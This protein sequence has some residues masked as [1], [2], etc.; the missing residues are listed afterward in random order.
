MK[1][2]DSKVGVT[3][4]I[5]KQLRDDFGVRASK[6]LGQN[7]LVDQ[8]I[9]SKISALVPDGESVIE[10]GPG[11]GSLTVILAANNHYVHAFEF[12]EHILEPLKF[13]LEKFN[14]SNTVHVEHQDIMSVDINATLEVIKSKTVIGNLPYNISATLLM[15]IAQYFDKATFVIAMVQKEVGDR[16][17]SPLKSR[18][19]SGVTL[20]SRFFMECEMCFEVPRNVFVPAPNVDSCVIKFTRKENPY[21]LVA[22]DDVED[23]FK[24]IDAGFSMRRKMLRQS[25]KPIL[26]VNTAQVI[27]ASGVDP[28]T[29]AEQCDLEDFASIFS[30]MKKLR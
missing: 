18:G 6:A 1:E 10:V 27:E 24:L 5:L 11:V 19:V 28:T 20:K 3:P 16:F 8:N 21:L 23:F 25:L 13:V 15:K 7:F 26:G 4:S 9:C 22:Q 14:V 17:C 30:E 29:R 12:D 2:Q